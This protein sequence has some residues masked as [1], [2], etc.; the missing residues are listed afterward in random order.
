MEL[1]RL[2]GDM[3]T[4]DPSRRPSIGAIMSRE[5]VQVPV[6]A[7]PTPPQLTLLRA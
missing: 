6:Q 5:I 2:I 3:L 4:K 1:R 7:T